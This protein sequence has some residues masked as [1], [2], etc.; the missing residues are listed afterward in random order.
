MDTVALRARTKRVGVVRQPMWGLQAPVNAPT[1]MTS[2]TDTPPV[3]T[4]GQAFKLSDWLAFEQLFERY[5][6]HYRS[7][8]SMRWALRVHR[9]HLL[10]LG[11]VSNV[12]G[13]LLTH[14]A[15]FESAVIEAGIAAATGRAAT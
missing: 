6:E 1:P 14:P 11:A 4:G 3:D 13:R 15:R 2:T 5:R 9:S 12:A 10:R 7:E 8:N